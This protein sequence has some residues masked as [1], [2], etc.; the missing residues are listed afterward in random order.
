MPKAYDEPLD[1]FAQEIQNCDRVFMGEA[2][3]ARPR[4]EI[5]TSVIV[6]VVSAAICAEFLLLALKYHSDGALLGALFAFL[7]CKNLLD[8]MFALGYVIF[9]SMI[10]LLQLIRVKPFQ[11]LGGNWF[12]RLVSITVMTVLLLT[13]VVTFAYALFERI[14]GTRTT[15]VARY[16]ASHGKRPPLP[17]TSALGG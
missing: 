10:Q 15:L 17:S 5:W 6:F 9:G 14:D 8:P 1:A 2:L 11:T 3:S 12:A 13:V 4:L 7:L 16:E